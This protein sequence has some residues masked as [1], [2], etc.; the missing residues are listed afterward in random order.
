MKISNIP[1]GAGIKSV[2]NDSINFIRIISKNLV[3]VTLDNGCSV[4]VQYDVDDNMIEY[5]DS[6]EE[7]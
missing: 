2:R 5:P 1:V 6:E 7:M 3:T 4:P